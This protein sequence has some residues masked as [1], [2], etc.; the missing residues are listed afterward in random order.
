L[1]LASETFVAMMLPATY[2]AAGAGAALASGTA[3]S[4]RSAI[5]PMTDSLLTAFLGRISRVGLA[6][7]SARSR[8]PGLDRVSQLPV[9][10]RD[11]ARGPNVPPRAADYGLPGQEP[12]KSLAR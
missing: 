12:V 7:G 10:T 9:M 6:I 8:R 1:T 11:A 5:A 3:V 4:T 2:L